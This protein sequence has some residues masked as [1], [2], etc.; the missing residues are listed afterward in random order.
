MRK[1]FN[2]LALLPATAVILPITVLPTGAYGAALEEIVVTARKREENLQKTPIAVTALSGEALAQAGINELTAIDRQTPNLTFTVGTGGGSSTVNAFIRGVGETDFI[3]T[4]DPAV[5]LY[6]DG[7]YLSRV[8]GAN[9]ELKDVAR[10]E[11]L[12]GPQGSL[13]GKNSIGGAINVVT[14]KPDGSSEAEL[15]LSAGSHNLKAVSVYGQT[16]L[17]ETLAASVS[18]LQKKAHGWQ[19][20]PMDDAGDVDLATARAIFNWTPNDRFESTFSVDWN[21][22]DQTGYPNVMLAFQ[23]GSFFGDLWNALN[24]ADPCCT[25]NTDI[26]RSGAGGSLPNDSVDG[27]GFNWTNSW[28]FENMQLKSITGYRKMDAVFGRDGDNSLSN[29]AGDVHDQQHEQL[30]QEFQFTGQHGALDWVAGV[31]YFEEESIDDTDLIIIQGIGTSV[32]YHN[33]QEATSYAVYGHASYAITDQLDLYAGIRYT[34]EEKDFTQQISNLDFGTP[35]TFFI[36]GV[37]VNSCQFNQAAAYFDCSQDW[38]NTSPKVGLM[39]QINAD[40]MTYAHVSRGFRSG[41]YNGRAFGSPSDMQEYDPEILTSYEAGIKAELLD[42]SL[43]LNASL[44]YNDY[45]D[46]QVLITR[47]GS[48]AVEN[49]STA[50]IAGAELEATWLVRSQWQIQAGLGYLKDD[51]DGWVDVTGDFTDTE[52][53]QTPD[54]TFNLASDYEFSLGDNGSLTLRADMKF[55]SDYYLNAVN[56]ELLHPGG[57][58]QFNASLVYRPVGERWEVAVLGSNLSDKRVLNAGFD[59]SG[60]FGFT[61]GSYNPP[62]NYTVN[63]KIRL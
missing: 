42:N 14:K 60:F 20:R 40:V 54:L 23:N 16:A 57:H 43:R 55:V 58:S 45:E 63:L 29:Y 11:V 34:A 22:Q 17:T 5:G 15:N 36:P 8:F 18:F 19:N 7:V 59:G 25:P 39:Y 12:R 27:L 26:D 1:L 32:S 6:L 9:M 47:A 50:S 37:P 31:Y 41:G 10:I 3:V 28:Q 49:A 4:T 24:P 2:S 44:F 51:S 13:F 21:E 38:S 48:V 61:E 35:H 56:T 46:I 30:S 62:R 53:K 52:L 33:V